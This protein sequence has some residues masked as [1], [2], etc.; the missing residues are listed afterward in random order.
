VEAVE[1]QLVGGQPVERRH[2]D[3]P[4]ERRRAAEADIVNQDDHDVGGASG[5]FTSKREGAVAFRA[6]ISVMVG[7]DGVLMGS[8][9]RSIAALEKGG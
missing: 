3:R 9:V 1:L 4:A 7:M 5:A 8:T 6:S 2:V